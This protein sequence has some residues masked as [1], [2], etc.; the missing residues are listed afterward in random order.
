MATAKKSKAKKNKHDRTGEMCRTRK[1]IEDAFAGSLGNVTTICD[2]LKVSRQTFY[3]WKEKHE[4]VGKLLEA[5]VEKTFDWV[6]NIL[7]STQIGR[8]HV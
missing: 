2:R 1:Q 6:D 7:F 4:W 5:E 3:S 8:A